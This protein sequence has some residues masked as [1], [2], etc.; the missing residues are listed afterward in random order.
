M[1]QKANAR[2]H[3]IWHISMTCR[4]SLRK[5]HWWSGPAAFGSTRPGLPYVVM[6][7]LHLQYVMLL[8]WYSGPYYSILHATFNWHSQLQKHCE[9]LEMQPQVSQTPQSGVASLTLSHTCG[10]SEAKSKIN[11]CIV[12]VPNSAWPCKQ[13]NQHWLMLSPNLMLP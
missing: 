5:T 13:C 2:M 6:Q 12:V 1:F 10:L 8:A 9:R 4:V 3:L 11:V 7:R